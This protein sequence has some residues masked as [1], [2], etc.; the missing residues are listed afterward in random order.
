MKVFVFASLIALTFAQAPLGGV[1]DS[2]CPRNEDPRNP[3]QFP[4][5]YDCESFF[6]CNRGNSFE[7]R[8]P[9]G[10]HWNREKNYCDS[11]WTARCVPQTP[12]RPA[13][14]P[15]QRPSIPN[16]RPEIEHPDFLNCPFVDTPGKIVYFPY[17]LNCQQFYQCVNGRAV[18][19][20]CPMDHAWDLRYNHCTRAENVIS[21]AVESGF[22]Q[23]SRATRAPAPTRR[24]TAGRGPTRQQGVPVRPIP[25]RAPGNGS[26][27]RQAAPGQPPIPTRAPPAQP[28]QPPVPTRA[29]PGQPPV[30]TRAPPGQPPVPT[31]APPGQPPVPTRPPPGQPPMPTAQPI[32]PPIPTWAPDVNP[33]NPD[34]IEIPTASVP[35]RTTT[36]PP[37]IS[38]V[39]VPDSRCPA[40][41]N[42]RNPVHLPHQ[43]NCERFFKC[44]HGM[45]FEYQCPVGQHWN[46]RRNYC[47]FPNLANCDQNNW[48]WSPPNN[49]WQNPP[50]WNNP[51]NNRPPTWDSNPPSW[52]SSPPTWNNPP[53]NWNNQIPQVPN[54]QHPII[55]PMAP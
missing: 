39:G 10:Q 16:P 13:P 42:P 35:Q 24:T 31:R 1:P 6:K 54:F 43:S 48:N 26:P 52:D 27:T 8:C 50:S 23:T 49:N 22:G 53:N 32:Q 29:P 38:V 51:S 47:D 9:N 17:H 15:P 25:T 2:R 46:A 55:I 20:R 12:Q 41:Q 28:G 45:A 21:I 30:P 36:R 44:D 33:N 11:P 14:R 4:N 18:L 3:T 5:P 40:N 7:V 19:L 37:R 34:G